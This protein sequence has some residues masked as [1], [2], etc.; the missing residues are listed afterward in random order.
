MYPA[1][2]RLSY[3]GTYGGTTNVQ[4]LNYQYDALGNLRGREDVVQGLSETFQYDAFNRLTE[5]TIAGVGTKTWS[6][7]GLGNITSKDGHGDYAYTSGRPHAVSYARGSTHVYDAN[8]SLVL[9]YGAQSRTITWNS[10]NLP[11]R[12]WANNNTVEFS[13]TPDGARYRQVATAGGV[14]TTTLYA[15]SH[16]EQVTRNGVTTHK[17]YIAAAGRVV[18]VREIANGTA[19]MKYLHQDH[20][21]STD[22]ITDAT[23]QVLE[24]QSFDAFGGRRVATTWHDPVA[25]LTSLFSTRGYTG[26]EQLDGV[27]LIHM[28]GRVYDPQL[29][30]FLSADP[31]VG[32][33]ANP[34]NLNR[35]SYVN[36]NPLSYTDPSGFF[37]KKLFRSIKKLFK[38]E[39]FRAVVGIAASIFT[40]GYTALL[41][42]NI[43]AASAAAGFVGGSITTGTLKG[44]LI[45]AAS[46]LMFAPLH[47]LSSGFGKTLAHGAVGGVRSRLLGGDFREGFLSAGFTQAMSGRI[48]RIESFEGRIA[49]AAVVGGTAAELGGGKFANGAVTGAFSRLFNDERPELLKKSYQSGAVMRAAAAELRRLTP[50]SRVDYAREHVF[51]LMA[52]PGFSEGMSLEEVLEN[53]DKL[54]VNNAGLIDRHMIPRMIELQHIAAGNLSVAANASTAYVADFTIG[55]FADI[56]PRGVLNS[57]T[58]SLVDHAAGTYSVYRRN[59]QVGCSLEACYVY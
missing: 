4:M 45:G 51:E 41:T 35:Y 54:A 46:A 12:I 59:P 19:S 16:H 15:G 23:G 11:T 49:A 50:M 31:Y 39:I 32:A 10:A 5:A 38:N 34:Q 21:G 56:S 48:G 8:G 25:A 6:Y 17:D 24:R 26:H 7:D 40:L 52:E 33:P 27:G 44:G 42:G 13:Y 43:Y 36:N 9:S 37:L 47:G 57:V 55:M 3:L 30:R 29:G 58:S 53:I 20:L 14:T 22:V 1:S 28:N 2:G 18:A